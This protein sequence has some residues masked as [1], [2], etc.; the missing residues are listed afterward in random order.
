MTNA[1]SGLRGA[2]DGK[3]AEERLQGLADEGQIGIGF[4][5]PW[6]LSMARQTGLG[7]DPGHSLVMKMQLAGDRS[8]APLLDM[9]VAQ[10]LC[11]GIRGD[12][13]CRLLS[14]SV[15]PCFDEPGGG[16]VSPSERNPGSSGCTDS[17]AKLS[18]AAF[19]PVDRHPV[20]SVLRPLPGS[21]QSSHP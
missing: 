7:Q 5:R 2:A 21:Q 12:G 18:A 20:G 6:R 4:R 3:V 14:C 16:A 17:N 19:L 10:D 13:H 9:V 15:E 1:I 8:G 11:L